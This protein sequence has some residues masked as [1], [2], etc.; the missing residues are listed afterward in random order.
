M[1]GANIRLLIPIAVPF[2]ELRQ[3]TARFTSGWTRIA[4]PPAGRAY[5]TGNAPPTG[6]L[7]TTLTSATNYLATHRDWKIFTHFAAETNWK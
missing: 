4:K 7:S 3:A 5:P 1:Y 2:R 6:P